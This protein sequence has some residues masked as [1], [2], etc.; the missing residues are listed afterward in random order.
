MGLNGRKSY[1][2]LTVSLQVLNQVNHLSQLSSSTWQACSELLCFSQNNTNR[3]DREL[4]WRKFPGCTR[5]L[6]VPAKSSDSAV[7]TQGHAG[8]GFIPA[9]QRDK[10][11]RKE[12][13]LL[14]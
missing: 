3:K 7:L 6:G 2:D 8:G 14:T 12:G 1:P 10:D 4:S 9:Q 11:R 5:T 13:H